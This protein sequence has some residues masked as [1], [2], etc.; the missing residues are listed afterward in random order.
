MTEE[1]RLLTSEPGSNEAPS[2][3]PDGQHIV[4]ESTRDGSSQI[5][6]IDVDGGNLRRLTSGGENFA[7]AGP[8]TPPSRAKTCSGAGVFVLSGGDT[9]CYTSAARSYGAGLFVQSRAAEVSF[10]KEFV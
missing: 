7:P 2:F 10:S 5:W 9:S 3:S 4:F 1:T 6:V 8:D